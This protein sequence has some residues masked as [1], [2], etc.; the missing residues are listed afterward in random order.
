MTKEVYD[1]REAAST[2]SSSIK[3]LARFKD[4][5][6]M[7]VQLSV[8]VRYRRSFFGVAWTMA[9]PLLHMGV[10]TLAFSTIFSTHIPRYPLYVFTGLMV[11]DFFGQTTTF[12]VNQ[13]IWGSPLLSRVWLPP[14]VFPLS[15]VGAGVVNF[16]L[17]LLPLVAVM[18]VLGH[19]FSWQALFFPVPMLF[20][21]MFSLGVGLFLASF[22][23]HFHDVI[24]M[25]NVVLR[26]WYF[27]TPIMYPEGIFPQ[28]F[29]VLL[30]ANPLHH[31]LRCFRQPLLQG[32]LPAGNTLLLAL[33]MSVATLLF[34]WWVFARH[35]FEF[36]LIG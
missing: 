21:A 30:D 20:L 26:A 2:F 19:P 35:R 18:L 8:T 3:E 16:L 32:Q 4:L 9:N 28:S 17:T 22:A 23:L 24:N 27:L 11:M 1:S 10:L 36:A 34:G 31:I 25:W 15:A 12:A 29:R 14:A 13:L 5:L 33:G 6:H 7:L